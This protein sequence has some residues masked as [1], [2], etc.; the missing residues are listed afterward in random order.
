MVLPHSSTN[1]IEIT[2][3]KKI[4]R[5]RMH[6]QDGIQGYTLNWQFRT[7]PGIPLLKFII[8]NDNT[9]EEMRITVKH[10]HYDIPYFID[11][12]TFSKGDYFFDWHEIEK[13]LSKNPTE[14]LIEY[15][16][17]K[18]YQTRRDSVGKGINYITRWQIKPYSLK[19]FE[20][21]LNIKIEPIRKE[22][23]KDGIFEFNFA[24]ARNDKY[25]YRFDNETVEKFWD[26]YAI[27][28]DTMISVSSDTMLIENE[29]DDD[30]Y[31]FTFKKTEKEIISIFDRSYIGSDEILFY[32]KNF[33]LIKKDCPTYSC[34]K[35]FFF[36]I[37]GNDTMTV[38]T[39]LLPNSSY[40]IKDLEF[41]KGSY[42]LKI[43]DYKKLT[44]TTGC[45]SKTPKKLH[46]ILFKDYRSV[47][48]YMDKEKNI[49][50]KDFEFKVIDLTDISNIQLVPMSKQ[51]FW[52]DKFKIKIE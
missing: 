9:K 8:R 39:Y 13:Y 2:D 7:G 46:N 38:Y 50:F 43:N 30:Y 34:F 52:D 35:K 15:E 21:T 12:T 41:K 6:F 40:Y 17:M 27:Y 22:D 32:N 11:L 4:K 16:G 31:L 18:F 42:F 49:Y 51:E 23:F 19:Y 28:I 26:E 5:T 45:H 20:D 36:F 29:F 14:E 1:Y 37:N 47:R 3:W 33:F 48:N 24:D 44:W 10:M 25:R